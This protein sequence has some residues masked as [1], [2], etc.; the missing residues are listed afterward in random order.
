MAVKRLDMYTGNVS[1]TAC[2]LLMEACEIFLVLKFKLLKMPHEL[3]E[4]PQADLSYLLNIMPMRN[5][6]YF[7][8]TVTQIGRLNNTHSGVSSGRKRVSKP[9]HCQLSTLKSVIDGVLFLASRILCKP[10]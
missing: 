7:S 1:N 5:L 4:T 9:Q 3:P 2:A 10:V 6:L 8:S